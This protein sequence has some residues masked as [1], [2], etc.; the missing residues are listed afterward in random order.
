MRLSLASRRRELSTELDGSVLDRR[1]EDEWLEDTELY[2]GARPRTTEVDRPVDDVLGAKL[3]GKE[4]NFNF[5]DKS[6]P[7]LPPEQRIRG[8]YRRHHEGSHAG[9]RVTNRGD[10]GL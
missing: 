10:L 6:V 2:H 9:T 7:N 1:K 4:Q 5:R 3:G 8:R